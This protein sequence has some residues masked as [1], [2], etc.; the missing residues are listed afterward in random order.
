MKT[1]SYFILAAAMLDA[2]LLTAQ[3]VVIDDRETRV[4]AADHDSDESSDQGQLAMLDYCMPNP[5]NT[6]CAVRY[7]IPSEATLSQLILQNAQGNVI[8]VSEP[9]QAGK[10]MYQLPVENL[11]NGNYY[12]TLTVD[13]AKIETRSMLISR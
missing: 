7:S 3:H 11:P 4:L 2:C 12:Y 5:V 8:F 9:L 6:S 13:F 1:L 10:G